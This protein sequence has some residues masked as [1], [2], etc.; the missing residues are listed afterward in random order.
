MAMSMNYFELFNLAPSFEIDGADL[1]QTYQTLQKLTHPD[2][3]ATAS[4]R[5]KLIAV[6]K[7]AQVN[8]AYQV[9]KSPLARAEH[10]LEL[11]GIELKHEQQTIQDTA[12]LMQQMEWREQLEDIGSL[13]DPL[14]ALEALD[15][16][17][18]A[19]LTAHLNKLQHLLD[20]NSPDADHQAATLVRKVK[21]LIK[22]RSEIELKEDALSDI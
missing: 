19:E 6:Q 11:R 21:F 4:E 17:I 22:L 7:N 9:L 14:T 20:E 5:E 2:K 10:M 8:D 3:F 16:E 1:S 13:N 18:H 15:D 12:F